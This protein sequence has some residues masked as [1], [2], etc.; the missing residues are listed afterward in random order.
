MAQISLAWVMS[1][2]YVSAPII[3][4]TKLEN[5][6]D[7][8]KAVEIKLTEEEVMGDGAGSMVAIEY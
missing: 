7:L 1:K 2:P 5:I 8:V 4:S 3:G 6:L